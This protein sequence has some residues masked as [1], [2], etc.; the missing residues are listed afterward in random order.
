MAFAGSKTSDLQ[1]IKTLFYKKVLEHLLREGD[2]AIPC[3]GEYFLTPIGEKF[4]PELEDENDLQN[5]GLGESKS[6]EVNPVD[7]VSDQLEEITDLELET[8]FNITGEDSEFSNEPV[9]GVEIVKPKNRIR[10]PKM[11]AL[12]STP[13]SIT[14]K[15]SELDPKIRIDKYQVNLIDLLKYDLKQA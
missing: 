15:L 5:F 7:S 1:G 14:W 8:E 13:E 9:L 11:I 2:L 12:D 6:A 10:P 3:I 4:V